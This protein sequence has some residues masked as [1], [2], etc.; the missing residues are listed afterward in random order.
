MNAI[1]ALQKATLEFAR[2][3]PVGIL[4]SH[5]VYIVTMSGV[6]QRISLTD[7]LTGVDFCAKLDYRS[8]L[9]LDGT[10]VEWEVVSV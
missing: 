9:E 4:R 1:E 10:S 3:K 8:I 2:V 6:L 5:L 7:D